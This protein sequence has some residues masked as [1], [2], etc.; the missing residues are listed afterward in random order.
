MLDFRLLINSDTC[1]KCGIDLTACEIISAFMMSGDTPPVYVPLAV[2]FRD[3][4][5]ET[6]SENFFKKWP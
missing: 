6:D 4:N 5:Y 1:T 3:L 2:F